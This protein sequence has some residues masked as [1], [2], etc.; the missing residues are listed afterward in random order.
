MGILRSK[1]RAGVA[2]PS[3]RG[4]YCREAAQGDV[5]VIS[6]SSCRRELPGTLLDT[7]PHESGHHYLPAQLR[8]QAPSTWFCPS[9]PDIWHCGLWHPVPDPRPPG[10]PSRAAE[11]SW[12]DYDPP[13][14]PGLL[15]G[16][17]PFHPFLAPNTEGV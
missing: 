6:L 16:K 13:K 2:S 4:P 5:P 8:D 3:V 9:Q 15:W 11:Q 17:K 10:P 14:P 1:T 7:S 12:S